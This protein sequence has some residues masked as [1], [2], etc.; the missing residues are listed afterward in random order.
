[1]MSEIP[2]NT[3]LVSTLYQLIAMSCLMLVLR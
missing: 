3:A 2:D 1:M